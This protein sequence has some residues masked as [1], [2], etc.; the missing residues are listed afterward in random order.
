MMLT[1]EQVSFAEQMCA[2]SDVVDC[3]VTLKSV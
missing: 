3:A 2:L 1:N